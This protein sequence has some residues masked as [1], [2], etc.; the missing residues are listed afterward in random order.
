MITVIDV[1]KEYN[2][3]GGSNEENERV[4]SNRHCSSSCIVGGL[5]NRQGLYGYYDRSTLRPFSTTTLKSR[6]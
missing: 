2:S 5:D 6:E 1:D 4:W 3:H